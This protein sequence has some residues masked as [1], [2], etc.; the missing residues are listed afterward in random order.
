MQKKLNT[1]LNKTFPHALNPCY[2]T[3]KESQIQLGLIR[4]HVTVAVVK[5]LLL[6]M[7]ECTRQ[8]RIFFV[9][10]NKICTNLRNVYLFT[11]RQF[12]V[13]SLTIAPLNV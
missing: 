8:P 7:M 2:E 4:D 3:R 6:F 5:M 10:A 13:T 11:H 12:H 1:T 9:W